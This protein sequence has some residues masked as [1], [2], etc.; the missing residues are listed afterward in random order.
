[1]RN[2]QVLTISVPMEIQQLIYYK[3]YEVVLVNL[4]H[5]Q[6]VISK[7][8]NDSFMVYG[9]TVSRLGW[10][11]NNT[12]GESIWRKAPWGIFWKNIMLQILQRKK[13]QHFPLTDEIYWTE[14]ARTE[15]FPN[16]PPATYK[17]L[18]N[19]IIREQ[20]E[21][22]IQEPWILIIFSSETPIKPS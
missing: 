13:F 2:W 22:W 9:K 15:D 12:L 5:K 17:S 6:N 7:V 21:Q 4:K 19:L 18:I 8:F 14:V 16:N 11:V 3:D 10:N 20:Q 1:M